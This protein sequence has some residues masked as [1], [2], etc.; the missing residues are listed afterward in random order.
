[1]RI[2]ILSCFIVFCCLNAIAQKDSLVFYKYPD[3]TISGEGFLKDG[4][5]EGYWKNYFPNGRIKSEGLLSNS[6]T[7]GT[8]KFYF[9]SGF[10]NVE[11]EY[12][13]G[14]KQGYRK[15][16]ADSGIIQVFDYF[17][18]DLRNGWA[19]FFDSKGVLNRKINY[20]NGIESGV[21]AEFAPDGRII[22][23]NEYRAG[24]QIRSTKVNRYDKLTK[25]TGIWVETDSLFRIQMSTQYQNGLKNGLRKYYDSSGNL[26]K[27]EK[28]QDDVLIPDEKQ[29]K[30][31]SVRNMYTAEG[32]LKSRGAYIDGVAAGKHT[33][34]NSSGQ[35]DS[36][37]IYSNGLVLETGAVDSAGRKQGE[38]KSFYP[39]GEIKSKGVYMDDKKSGA[40][41]FFYN[42]GKTEQSGKYVNGLPDGPWKWYY[43][44][45]QIL[46]DEFYRKGRE[47]GFAYELFPTGDTLSAGEFID[48]QREGLWLFQ[49]GDQ[50]LKGY[51]VAGEMNGIWT[52]FY[53]D[54]TRSFEGN[55]RE[56]LAEG[57]IRSWHPDGTLKWK[58]LCDA[59]KR[60][61]V[62]IR[63]DENGNPVF[64]IT[65]EDGVEKK[66]NGIHIY[67]EF[68]QADYES[69]IQRNPY[70]F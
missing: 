29:I 68:F 38:W 69:L 23:L 33:Y 5:P 13:Q 45:G 52:H 8:W 11:T 70:V 12:N 47:D 57:L 9:E 50:K 41:T 56:G 24:S 34:Y 44:D 18:N 62:W 30:P 27:I 46:R 40:W 31:P 48:G 7:Q 25:R 51:F 43:E 10:I 39:D 53:P 2:Y 1:M 64:S 17:E 67:P 6:Q 19:S 28:Y 35:S 20:E 58:G 61:G 54:G 60:T 59:G 63:Y 55:F 4:K 36:S 14:K 16:Y 32:K 49:D 15:L 3:G 37:V 26:L 66:Y 21:S 65:Y 42:N 22:S